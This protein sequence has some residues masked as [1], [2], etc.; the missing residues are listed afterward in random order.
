MYTL[1]IVFVGTTQNPILMG[2][3][4]KLMQ[5]VDSLRHFPDDIISLEIWENVALDTVYRWQSPQWQE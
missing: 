5:V 2:S 1:R 4:D 3:Y